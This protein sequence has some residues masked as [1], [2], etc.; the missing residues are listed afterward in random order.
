LPHHAVSRAVVPKAVDLR[1]GELFAVPFAEP[2]KPKLA[3]KPPEG[4]DWLYEIK[5]DGWRAQCHVFQDRPRIYTKKGLDV[6]ASLPVISAELVALPVASVV[7]DAEACMVREDGTTDF[8]ALHAAM[9]R[10][11]APDA[12]LYCFDILHLDG[13]DLRK[14]PL[15]ERR[16]ILAE[17]LVDGGPHLELSDHY[18]GDPKPLLRAACDMGLEGIVAKRKDARYRSGYVETW[19]KVKCTQQE[20]FAVTGYEAAGRKGVSSLKVATLKGEELVPCGWVGSGLAADTCSAIRAALDDG[21][22][23]VVDVEYRGWT[24]SGELRHAVFK[25]WHEG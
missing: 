4:S 23:V 18:V 21:R 25:G 12:V 15:I 14:L 8:F 24:P 17:L 10:K 3:T 11:S 2:M 9:D 7:L 1:Q 22:Q 16:A 20:S 6:S 13:E 5:H 19:L